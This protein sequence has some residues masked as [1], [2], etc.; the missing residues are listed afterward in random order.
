[1][2]LQ[3]FINKLSNLLASGLAEAEVNFDGKPIESLKFV[4]KD[5]VQYVVISSGASANSA[6]PNTEENNSGESKEGS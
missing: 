2:K 1:M 3:E 6:T 4:E 5:G